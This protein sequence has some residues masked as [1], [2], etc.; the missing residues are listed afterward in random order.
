[1]VLA[2]TKYSG[3]R[4]VIKYIRGNG[5]ETWMYSDDFFVVHDLSH[6]ALEKTLA[7]TTAFTGMLN[8]GTAIQDFEDRAKR[9]AMQLTKEAMYAENMANLFLMETV[10]GNFEDINTVIKDAFEAI[11]RQYPAPVLTE[12]EI[13]SIRA[14]LRE[15][16]AQWNSLPAGKTM[17]LQF[18]I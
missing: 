15:L 5:T 17:H 6:F 4:H 16:L 13:N 12:T 3:K 8:N 11:T 18:D 7:Y 1:M 14:Y 10:Q 2:I 9:N